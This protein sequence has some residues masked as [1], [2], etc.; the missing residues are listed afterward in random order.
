[1]KVGDALAMLMAYDPEE[2]VY[3]TWW[4]RNL[5]AR[6][7]DNPTPGQ[8]LVGTMPDVEKW[9]EIVGEMEALEVSGDDFV[10]DGVWGFIYDKLM[11]KG[12]YND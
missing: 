1:M 7:Y 12:A 9:N 8:E 6:I 2:E 11:A 3:I 10:S 4:D 5:F